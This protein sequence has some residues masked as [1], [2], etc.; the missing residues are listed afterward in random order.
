MSF[1]LYNH[2]VQQKKL[3]K[4]Y[5]IK[6][7]VITFISIL[8]KLYIFTPKHLCYQRKNCNSIVMLMFSMIVSLEQFLEV[9]IL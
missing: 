9:Q 2:I 4:H 8:L 3:L 5:S 7:H 1:P 6:V